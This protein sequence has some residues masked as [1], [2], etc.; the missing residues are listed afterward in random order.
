[1]PGGTV[2][3][4]T[5]CYV[6][7][8]CGATLTP[9]LLKSVVTQQLL[10]WSRNLDHEVGEF[11]Y[12]HLAEVVCFFDWNSVEIVLTYQKT[13]VAWK[14]MT[15]GNHISSGRWWYLF[16]VF[17]FS[18]PVRQFQYYIIISSQKMRYLWRR[19]NNFLDSNGVLESG[20][21]KAP[22]SYM[23]YSEY[24]CPPFVKVGPYLFKQCFFNLCNIS[25]IFLR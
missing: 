17:N 20:W 7:Q 14:N 19:I 18:G 23:I 1:M 6:V 25:R 16:G 3:V 10:V 9:W 15:G 4:H 5:V 11:M 21:Y 2:S 8:W 22:L 12:K 24:Y 13:V